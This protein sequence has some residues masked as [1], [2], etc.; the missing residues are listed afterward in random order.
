[1]HWKLIRDE[2]DLVEA[3]GTAAKP[4]L[5]ESSFFDTLNT[6]LDIWL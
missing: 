1:V 2:F 6:T 5:T 3:F 4:N